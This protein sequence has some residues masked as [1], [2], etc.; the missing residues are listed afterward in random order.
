MTEIEIYNKAIQDFAKRLI[1]YYG[2]I[3]KTSGASVQY[4]AKQI[5]NELLRRNN[6]EN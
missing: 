1:T 3:D 4:Y 6:N 5:K 2:N